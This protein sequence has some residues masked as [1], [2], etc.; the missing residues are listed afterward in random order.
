MTKHRLSDDDLIEL[1]LDYNNIKN[2]KPKKKVIVKKRKTETSRTSS[3]TS[4]RSSGATG[5]KKR[6]SK[7]QVKKQK[8][9][10]KSRRQQDEECPEVEVSAKDIDENYLREQKE[11]EEE[12][13]YKRYKRM[14]RQYEKK[15][16]KKQEK[17]LD[18]WEKADRLMT[19]AASIHARWNAL[20]NI[21]LDDQNHLAKAVNP[22]RERGVREFREAM[23]IVHTLSDEDKEK[24]W[25]SQARNRDAKCFEDL[26]TKKAFETNSTSTTSESTSSA[27][28]CDEAVGEITDVRTVES[29]VVDTP[30]ESE[31]QQQQSSETTQQQDVDMEIVRPESDTSGSEVA[32]T[33]TSL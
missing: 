19:N 18:L 23:D 13:T 10:G 25:N 1:L 26:V 22:L 12:K 7:Q 27:A 5:K 8:K 15:K 11:K 28:S 32:E 16:Q 20:R 6:T 29:T 21:N 17:Q 14:V 33:S 3:S 9:T 4:S 2:Q 31:Q 30:I 24:F